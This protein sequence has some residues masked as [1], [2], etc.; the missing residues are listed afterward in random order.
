[1]GGTYENRNP[2]CDFYVFS[3]KHW[4]PDFAGMTVWGSGIT[5][6]KVLPSQV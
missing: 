3:D 6:C 5:D 2:D 1:M 4:I